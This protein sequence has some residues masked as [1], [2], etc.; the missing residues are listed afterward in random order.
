MWFSEYIQ[1]KTFAGK[2]LLIWIK[3]LKILF[4]QILK[5]VQ[6]I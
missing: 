1:F 6:L 5:P 4:M 2:H 3:N